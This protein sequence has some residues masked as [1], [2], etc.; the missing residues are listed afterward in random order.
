[1]KKNKSCPRICSSGAVFL[2]EAVPGPVLRIIANGHRASTKQYQAAYQVASL[3]PSLSIAPLPVALSDASFFFF[4]VLVAPFR[5]SV[6]VPAARV[7]S[8]QDVYF[9][10]VSPA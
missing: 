5:F 2:F 1:M 10:V 8:H 7:S 3:I 9:E 4:V 6:M